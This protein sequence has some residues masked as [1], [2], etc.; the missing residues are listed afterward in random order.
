MKHKNRH[1]VGVVISG[2][3]WYKNIGKNESWCFHFPSIKHGRV[4]LPFISLSPLLIIIF[5]FYPPLLFISCMPFIKKRFNSGISWAFYQTKF[6]IKKKLLFYN[7]NIYYY[8]IKISDQNLANNS[9][10]FVC[11]DT[12]SWEKH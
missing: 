4:M 1:P 12:D 9:S 6:I 8:S 10:R 11:C 2:Y 7:V 3:N 5:T